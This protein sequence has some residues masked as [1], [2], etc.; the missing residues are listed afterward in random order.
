MEDYILRIPV[1]IKFSAKPEEAGDIADEYQ[2][3]VAAKIEGL[4]LFLLTGEDPEI[5]E[6]VLIPQG[7]TEREL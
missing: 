4:N 2:A 3:K 7:K 5:L 1:D 6:G